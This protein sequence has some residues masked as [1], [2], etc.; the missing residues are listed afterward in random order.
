MTVWLVCLCV[1]AALSQHQSVPLWT[2]RCLK[3]VQHCTDMATY[4]NTSPSFSSSL[5]LVLVKSNLVFK[6]PPLHC[7]PQ[8]GGLVCHL[9]LFGPIFIFLSTC[10][11]LPPRQSEESKQA[12]LVF[13]PC[14][15]IRVM[16]HCCYSYCDS[17]CIQAHTMCSFPF[18][19]FQK[20]LEAMYFYC[21][22]M[23]STANQPC[24]L[25]EEMYN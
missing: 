21:W 8:R 25:S 20:C 9:Y 22:R 7:T 23:Y 16:Y 2:E 17:E 19:L 12:Y 15:F 11:S 3:A 24:Y 6:P 1:Y 18:C 13:S 14:T 10:D 4:S 5:T